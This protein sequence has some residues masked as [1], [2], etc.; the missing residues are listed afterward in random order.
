M[1]PS[2]THEVW[3]KNIARL[4]ELYAF[5]KNLDLRGYGST[6][7]KNEE[8]Q[9]A[10]EPDECYVV[11]RPLAEIPDFVIEVIYSNPLL[12]KLTVY[13][14]LGVQEVWVF[15][16]G[17]FIVHRRDAKTGAYEAHPESA[18]VPGLDFALLARYVLRD[19][20]I[21]ALKEFEAEVR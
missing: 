1:S 4:L 19:D 18:L 5:I 21:V 20:G 12:D 9:R 3:K 15:R 16:G 13:A 11:G 10:L 6:T 8:L 2:S 7:F 17:K 14:S